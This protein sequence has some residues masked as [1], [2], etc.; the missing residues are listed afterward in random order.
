MNKKIVKNLFY[1]II[2]SFFGYCLES[3]VA[4][5]T[6]GVIESRQSFVYGPFCVI[7]G[8]G[9]IILISILSNFKNQN[10]KLFFL[11]MFI[12]CSVEYLG[13]FIG[14]KLLGFAWWNYSNMFLNING[15]TSLFYAICWGIISIFLINF[16]NPNIDK[17]FE[18]LIALLTFPK[19]QLA[20][21]ILALFFLFDALLSGFALNNFYNNTI[22]ANNIGTPFELAYLEDFHNAFKNS[23]FS[24]FIN[25]TFTNEKMI[26]IYPN[27][28]LPTISGIY[29]NV[30]SLFN[31]AQ[32]YYLKVFGNL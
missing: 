1:L 18:K 2:Y 31:N 5:V 25:K 3:I 32:T 6:K 13:S 22:H 4:I 8:I 9:A 7:Y 15:R 29:I 10:F 23:G 12:G 30:D 26:K 27:I 16:I 14:E 19:L 20:T 28:L 21:Y 11:G 17:L 24:N